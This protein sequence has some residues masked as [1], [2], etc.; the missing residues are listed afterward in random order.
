MP[1]IIRRPMRGHFVHR[2]NYDYYHPYG[3]YYSYYSSSSPDLYVEPQPRSDAG[4]GV[5]IVLL[6][7]TSVVAVYGMFVAAF[8]DIILGAAIF[9]AAMVLVTLLVFTIGIMCAIDKRK[10][11]I[12]ADAQ[13]EQSNEQ[14]KDQDTEST[15]AQDTKTEQ[16]NAQK[17]DQPP[18][19]GAKAQEHDAG[20]PAA[21]LGQTYA[22][23]PPSANHAST[24]QDSAPV[25]R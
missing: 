17:T 14:Q 22:Q 18:T 3:V 25:G 9:T 13:A 2:Y 7:L 24:P 6:A 20:D 16:H 10:D 12:L 19:E 5:C 15:K 4:Y 23:A 1:V 11:K 8:E 21:S